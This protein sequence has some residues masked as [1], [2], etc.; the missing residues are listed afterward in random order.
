MVRVVA[1]QELAWLRD[2]GAV[3]LDIRP[4]ESYVQGHLPGALHVSFYQPIA[5]WT[6]WQVARRVGYAMF[7][8][9]QGTEANPNFL[10]EVSEL[11]SDPASTPVVL[12][13]NLGGSLE[14]TKTDPNGQQTR[15]MVAAYELAQAGFKALHVLKGGYN[16]WVANDR[17][18]EVIE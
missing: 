2:K 18:I 5:G 8:I 13:C 4:E 6:P 9:S 11:V 1:P 3:L 15:S 12:Y 7:G 10:E 17:D 14:P 16:D